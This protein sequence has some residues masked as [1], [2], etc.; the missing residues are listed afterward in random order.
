[1]GNYPIVFTTLSTP[2]MPFTGVECAVS[3]CFIFAQRP[4]AF[5]VLNLIQGSQWLPILSFPNDDA[6]DKL[7]VT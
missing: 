3:N 4:A 6:S 2:N 7:E 5:A 1:M